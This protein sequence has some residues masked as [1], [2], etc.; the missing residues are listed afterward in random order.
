M[1]GRALVFGDHIGGA[2]AAGQFDGGVGP[3][4]A[5]GS[6]A[7]GGEVGLAVG[8]DHLGDDV[9]QRPVDDGVVFVVEVQDR[10]AQAVLGPGPGQ[11][12][13]P[14]L[15]FVVGLADIAAF[16]EVPGPAGHRVPEVIRG[17]GHRPAEDLL[18]VLE[19][20]VAVG[21]VGLIG[22][23]PGVVE[24]D[25]GFPQCFH[26]VGSTARARATVRRVRALWPAMPVLTR[27][28]APGSRNQSMPP[29][30]SAST[31]A[32][33]SASSASRAARR[34][35][36]SR[37]RSTRESGSVRVSSSSELRA[38]EWRRTSVRNSRWF[39]C[40]YATLSA[41]M[42]SS[43]LSATGRRL[44]VPGLEV[45]PVLLQRSRKRPAQDPSDHRSRPGEPPGPGRGAPVAVT[46]CRRRPGGRRR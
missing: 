27:S 23:D 28:Q 36:R 30:R 46:P 33:S 39:S 32:R 31:A 6:G 12:A 35:A 11:L 8:A 13:A 18:D 15:A 44:V 45:G 1:V 7:F 17:P 9:P 3:D 29:T 24:G 22:D 26:T 37:A 5:G 41:G 42:L 40:C 10:A 19:E 34:A 20:V 25:P 16:V 21:G 38:I 14:A 43:E 4:L 2:G